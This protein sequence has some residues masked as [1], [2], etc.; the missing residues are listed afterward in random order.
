MGDGLYWQKDTSHAEVKRMIFFGHLGLTAGAF[1]LFERA[2]SKRREAAPD[3]DY[4][5]VLLGSELPDLLD[6][7]I[8]NVLFRSV[9]NSGRIF[10][11]TL[12]L[13]LLVLL[14]GFAL[15]RTRRKN[16]VLVLGLA[17]LLHL[18]FDAMWQ[19]PG[20]LLWPFTNLGTALRAESGRLSALLRFPAETTDWMENSFMGLAH[21][22][23]S[24]LFELAGLSILL[25]FFVKLLRDRWLG[26]FLRTGRPGA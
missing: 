11:H 26:G 9:F 5:L 1:R 19:L 16:G 15:Y 3:I 25:Y 14:I 7:P 21:Y 12:L 8:G 10:G 17:S 18:I 20:T 4:R 2:T 22:L 23:S 13:T 24:A 6:K